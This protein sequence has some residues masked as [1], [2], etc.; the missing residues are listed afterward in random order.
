MFAVP[1]TYQKLT[2]EMKNLL[3]VDDKNMALITHHDE[4]HEG[5]FDDDDVDCNTPNTSKFDEIATKTPT[6]ID[7]QATST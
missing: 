6:S 2:K 1:G 4:G 5:N 3:F 7:K